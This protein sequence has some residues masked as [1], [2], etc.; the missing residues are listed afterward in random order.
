MTYQNPK[1][2]P[3]FGEPIKCVRCGQPIYGPMVIVNGLGPCHA[4]PNTICWHKGGSV[5]PPR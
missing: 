1:P 5:N 2:R 4:G 3:P